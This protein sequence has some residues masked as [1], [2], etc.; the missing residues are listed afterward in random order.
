MQTAASAGRVRCGGCRGRPCDT[1]R[2]RQRGGPRPTCPPP[3][4]D[5]ARDKAGN[6]VQFAH[7]LV[8]QG[9][10]FAPDAW[11]QQF[12]DAGT[13]FAGPVPERAVGA[14]AGQ[15]QIE[16]PS[17]TTSS[18]SIPSQFAATCW[19][20]RRRSTPPTATPVPRPGRRTKSPAGPSPPTTPRAPS[21][22]P[23]TP[24]PRSRTARR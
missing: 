9:G 6:W 21:S 5:G 4:P 2:P 19:P 8:S 20:R 22:S 18:V 7:Q 15:P 13:E 17:W 24:C 1:F 12:V 14:A 16:N 10:K 3:H 23:R 11:A